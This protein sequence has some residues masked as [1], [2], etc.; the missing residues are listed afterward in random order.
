MM[1]QFLILSIVLSMSST[2]LPILYGFDG[3]WMQFWLGETACTF[4]LGIMIIQ[5][6]VECWSFLVNTFPLRFA[7]DRAIT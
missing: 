7:R 3:P 1:R 4:S 6:Y 2:G 5:K